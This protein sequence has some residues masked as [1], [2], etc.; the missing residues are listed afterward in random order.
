MMMM[1]ML[2]IMMSSTIHLDVVLGEVDGVGDGAEV[3]DGD[4]ARLLE[5]LRHPHRVQTA[6]Q[7]LLRLINGTRRG[8][9]GDM[10]MMIMMMMMITTRFSGCRPRSNRFSA[11]CKTSG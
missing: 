7:Q 2:M 11:W 3:G 8:G 9:V 4:L 1:M 5:A 10:M 6:V